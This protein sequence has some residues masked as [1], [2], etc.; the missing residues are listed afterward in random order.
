MTP[1]NEEARSDDSDPA[2]DAAIEWFVRLRAGDLSAG[3]AADFEKWRAGSPQ[4]AEAFEEVLQMYGHLAGMNSSRRRAGAH[5]W[6]RR[7]VA[8]A[9][10]FAAASLALIDFADIDALLRSDYRAGIGETKLV[11]LEDGSRV[12]LDSRT[13]IALRYAASERRVILLGGEAWFDVAPDAARPF[14]VEAGGGTVTALG[15]A[16][17]VALGT[18]GAR[19]IV[20]KRRVKVSNGGQDVVVEEGQQSAYGPGAGVEPPSAVDATSATAWRRGKLI[21]EK[22]PLGEAL[23]ALG[24]YRRGVIYCVRASTCERRIS[25]VFGSDDPLQSLREIE[26]SLGLRAIHLTSYVILLL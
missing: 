2:G 13:S 18:S 25:G 12:Q 4:N 1:M 6:R 19:V 16:F 15:T 8:G 24:R 11:T 3:E 20:A 17:D 10:A 14:V 7:I 9:S 26:A 21:V 22:K 5:P 23:Q